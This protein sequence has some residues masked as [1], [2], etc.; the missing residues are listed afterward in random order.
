MLKVKIVS[1]NIK[2]CLKAR[3]WTTPD[4]ARRTGMP[5]STLYYRM[6]H[7]GTFQAAELM[8][9]G[10][11]LNITLADIFGEDYEKRIAI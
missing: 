11:V 7:P 1:N 2:A 8:I 6:Q 3:K 5:L 10:H 9:I 4:L